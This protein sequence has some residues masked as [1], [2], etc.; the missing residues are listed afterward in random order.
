MSTVQHALTMSFSISM[1]C[2]VDNDCDAIGPQRLD[3]GKH[4]MN[5]SHAK[6]NQLVGTYTIAAT[7]CLLN[8]IRGMAWVG[9]ITPMQALAASILLLPAFTHKLQTSALQPSFADCSDSSHA[10]LLISFQ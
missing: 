4:N 5:C 7:A 10:H 9:Y 3:M 6:K 2:A 1:Q 8:I